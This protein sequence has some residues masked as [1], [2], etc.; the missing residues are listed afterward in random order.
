MTLTGDWARALRILAGAPR[1]IPHALNV[2]V[3]REA[4]DLRRRMI[5]GIDSGAPAGKKFAPH[6][7][8]TLVVRKMRGFKG[9]KILVVTGA[10]RGSI[11]VVSTGQG[12]AFVGV[13]RRR[14]H[15]SG[16]SAVDIAKI[17][18]FG[19]T[20]TMPMT[21]RMR[22]FLFAAIKKAGL[23]P[24]PKAKGAPGV[25]SI[26]IRIPP[27]PFIGP[28]VASHDRAAMVARFREAIM[29]ALTKL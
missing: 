12:S 29:E 24:R 16:K 10:L 4:H 18:E 20:W 3:L 26:T 15:P 14:R 27:R 22:R 19:K 13:L 5:E 2:A 9:S 8:L 28:V 6:S 25:A 23:P 11:A 7:P 17:H 21:D 1:A